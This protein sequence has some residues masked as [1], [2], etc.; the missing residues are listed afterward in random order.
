MI[1]VMV[2]GKS[3][4]ARTFKSIEARLGRIPSHKVNSGGLIGG[5]IQGSDE[6]DTSPA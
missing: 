2:F 4:L 1:V 5:W 6:E 3:D